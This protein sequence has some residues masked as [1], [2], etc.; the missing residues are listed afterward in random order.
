M[1]PT[2]ARIQAQDW[3]TQ[4]TDYMGDAISQDDLLI[5]CRQFYFGE[6]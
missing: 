6:G 1:E 2:R 3:F 5:Y 4:W